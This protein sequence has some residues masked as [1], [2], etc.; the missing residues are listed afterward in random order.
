MANDGAPPD[1]SNANLL[2]SDE[3]LPFMVLNADANAPVLLVC[4]HASRRFPKALGSMG[5]DPFARRCHLAWDIGAGPLTECL[6]ATLG[7]TAVLAQY[8]RLVVDCNRDL[9]DPGAFLEYGDGV[10]VHGNRNLNQA[11]K[12]QRASE[13][14][15]PY[16]YAIDVELKRLAA[17]D[18]PT[19]FFAIHSFTPVMNGIARDVEIGIL[20]DADRSTAEVMIEGFRKAGFKVGDNEPY[21]GK[22]PQDFTIDHHAEDAALPHVG[23]EIRQ[24]L[25]DND[26]GVQA[27][28]AVMHSIIKPVV[29]RSQESHLVLNPARA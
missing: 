26:A 3:P 14:Y 20:W 7:V 4:D 1:R 9:F 16:H 15:W 6:A 18:Y 24:D 12:D 11:L 19:A 8:S 22:A 29:E 21:S 23:I 27:I 13:L 25:I 17:F 28:A 2:A 10:V 5:L